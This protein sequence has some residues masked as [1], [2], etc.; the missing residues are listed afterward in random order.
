MS[1]PIQALSD[2]VALRI[3]QQQVRQLSVEIVRMKGVE[4]ALDQEVDDPPDRR[5]FIPAEEIIR[6]GEKLYFPWKFTKT[7]TTGGTVRA[8]NAY[9]GGVAKTVANWASYP[10]AL[11]LSGVTTTTYYYIAVD[12]QNATATWGSNTS[13]VPANTATVE[14]WHVLTLTCTSSVIS[15]IF[16]PWPCDIRALLNP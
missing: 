15:E 7:S 6:S 8:G 3:L 13:A 11:T 16:Q 9:I 14:Y 12:F 4:D 2:A 1:N 5:P 10:T